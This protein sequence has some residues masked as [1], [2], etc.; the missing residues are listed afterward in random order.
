MR[1]QASPCDSGWVSRFLHPSYEGGAPALQELCP[2]SEIQHGKVMAFSEHLGI[3]TALCSW[4]SHILLYT[5]EDG[6][7]SAGS[8]STTQLERA[9]RSL[10]EPSRKVDSGQWGTVPP[11]WGKEGGGQPI[12]SGKWLAPPWKATLGLHRETAHP[13]GSL[14]LA[15]YLTAKWRLCCHFMFRLRNSGCQ[16]LFLASSWPEFR[17]SCA[18]PRA[19]WGFII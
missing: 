18:K 5:H 12:L 14:G 10:M 17:A 4:S 3:H 8:L 1:K 6:S 19:V 2:S 11:P 13:R 7:T 15:L 16:R 9:M